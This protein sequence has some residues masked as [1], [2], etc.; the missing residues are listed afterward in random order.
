MKILKAIIKSIVSNEKKIQIF[1]SIY[2]YFY[3]SITSRKNPK[4]MQKTK[5]NKEEIKI[6]NL[7]KYGKHQ[8]DVKRR[9][10]RNNYIINNKINRIT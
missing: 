7:P 1:L 5:Y 4:F 9:T 10:K 2:F 3:S 6:N 8:N